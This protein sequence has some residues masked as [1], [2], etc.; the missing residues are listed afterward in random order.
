MAGPADGDK[1]R[2]EVEDEGEDGAVAE[3]SR[4]RQW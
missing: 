1:G 2:E 3:G 4:P